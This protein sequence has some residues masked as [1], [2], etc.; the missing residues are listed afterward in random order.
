MSEETEFPK[1]VEGFGY[2]FNEKGELRDIKTG[3][4]FEFFYRTGDRYYNQRRY[5]EL[6]DVIGEFIENELVEQYN[7]IRKIIPVELKEDDNI[8]KSRI[9]ISDDAQECQ[10]LLLLIQGSGVVRPG[11]WARQVIINDSLELGTMFPYIRKA[12]E[13]KWGIVIFNPNENYG[14]IMK[15]GE[16]RDRRIFGSES[17]QNHCLYVWDKF[18]TNAKAKEILIVAHSYGGICTSYLLDQY[19]GDFYK[20]VKGIALTDSVHSSG[21][22]P[23][24]SKLW[25]SKK[26]FNWIKSDLPMND[27]I[28]EANQ[29]YGCKCFSAG[30]H[31]HE[32]TS[33]VAI[34][35]V[36]EFLQFQA[37]GNKEITNQKNETSEQ[38]VT[39]NNEDDKESRVVKSFNEETKLQS[40]NGSESITHEKG[41]NDMEID[42]LPEA[43]NKTSSENDT[44]LDSSSAMETEA[45]SSEKDTKATEESQLDS[46]SAMEMEVEETSSEK[47]IKANGES[48]LDSSSTM[49]TETIS[50][51]KD[52]KV[53]EESQLDSSSTMET[54]ETSSEK[55]TKATEESRLD[56]SSA[57]KMEVE[58][59]SSE[60]DIKANG[61]SQLD[62]SSTMKTETISSEKDIKVTE[63]S[64]LDSSSTMETE[65]T[66]SEKDTK[67]TE[68]SRLDSSSA[69][70]ME[71]E[72]TSSEKD[73]KAN[74]ESQLDS[75]STMKTETISSEKDIKV[76]EESQLD[77]SSTMETEET[78]SEK[79]TKA[80]EESQLDS[81]SAMEMEVEETSSEK[82][83]KANGESQLDS[84][85]TM[86]TETIISEKDTKATEE[87]QLDSSSDVKIVDE[88]V[89]T[90]VISSEKDTTAIEELTGSETPNAIMN[91]QVEI[92]AKATN[93]TTTKTVINKQTNEVNLEKNT[94]KDTLKAFMNNAIT[95]DDKNDISENEKI[96]NNNIPKENTTDSNF[97][98]DAQALKD[99]NNSKDSSQNN[100]V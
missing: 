15:D 25:F 51:E 70:E 27:P 85:S 46:S 86:K 61:E 32:Y 8:A 40:Q 45:T 64:Q 79:D 5:E 83:I 53:T 31:K 98:T 93:E 1:T 18:V 99:D 74:G 21:M 96:N 67:A 52:I 43:T 26:A 20:R 69:M 49:K 84:S 29:F 36:F 7:L 37:R 60:K 73:I 66:S 14:S 38:S 57:M 89:A 19:A 91:E 78:S 2:R 90:N 92:V 54:E 59:T 39:N 62:S 6:G 34:E 50:S 81:S 65:E 11:Q 33:G 75:S 30:H 22:I 16:V 94:E 71:V 17:P 13:L 58:E 82:D 10:T 55:D 47:D 23:T 42:E 95:N 41:T 28:R 44:K 9:Y 76:T 100:N 80:T 12:Q 4:R 77:S 24:H 63:E 3:G 97:N 87:S 48:Q 56:S 88:T 68:E 35:P 72:E